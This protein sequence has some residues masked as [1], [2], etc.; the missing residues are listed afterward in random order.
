MHGVAKEA[1]KL[2]DQEQAKAAIEARNSVKVIEVVPLVRKP[3]NPAAP[4]QSIVVF[5]ESSDEANDLIRNQMRLETGRIHNAERYIPEL[6]LRQCFKCQ[7]YGHTA[8]NC[9]RTPKCGK[10]AG[11]HESRECKIPESAPSK[12]GNCHG[13]HS[14]WHHSCPHR[15]REIDRLKALK[16][17]TPPFFPTNQ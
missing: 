2:K 7:G 5:T 1:V 10:C 13:D 12:C 16:D 3:K 8:E 9:T 14:A 15:H 4:T 11:E 6:Q 17:V